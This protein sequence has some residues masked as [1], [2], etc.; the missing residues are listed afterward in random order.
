MPRNEQISFEPSGLEPPTVVHYSQPQLLLNESA[1]RDGSELVKGRRSNA[2]LAEFGEVV[3]FK[4]P[5]TKRTPGKF[6]DLLDEG[7]WLGF[8]MW[9]GEHLM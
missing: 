3:H 8:E 1:K 7:L 5:N 6:E 2:R 9:S 4:I